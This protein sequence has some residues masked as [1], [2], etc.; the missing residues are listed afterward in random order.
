MT[1]TTIAIVYA[2]AVAAGLAEFV[3]PIQAVATALG[4]GCDLDCAGDITDDAAE[5]NAVPTDV[6]ACRKLLGQGIYRMIVTAQGAIVDDRDYGL[7][8]AALVNKAMTPVALQALSGQIRQAVEKDDR[9]DQATV[10]LTTSAGETG[11]GANLGISILVK[12]EDPSLGPFSLVM[13]V[14]DGEALLIAIDSEVNSGQ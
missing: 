6:A 12:P 8:I 13:S 4:F 14:T 7:G 10:R 5:I 2:D 11:L 1:A 3:A 9:V